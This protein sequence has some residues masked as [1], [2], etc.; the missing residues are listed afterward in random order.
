MGDI[1]KNT[2]IFQASDAE[3]L[4]EMIILDK[5]VEV[6]VAIDDPDDD[7]QEDDV[8]GYI[9]QYCHGALLHQSVLLYSLYV[10]S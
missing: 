5:T 9:T 1:I 10:L 8:V 3:C 4:L 2:Y 7:A 6:L